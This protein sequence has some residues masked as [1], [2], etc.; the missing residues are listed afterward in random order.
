MLRLCGPNILELMA[1][2]LQLVGQT[3]SHYHIIEQIG[4][5]GGMGSF[6]ALGMSS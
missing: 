5:G 6:T 1:P 4:A 2:P 3:L